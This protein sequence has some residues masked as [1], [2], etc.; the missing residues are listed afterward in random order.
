M[1]FF[2]RDILQYLAA[3]LLFFPFLLAPGYVAAYWSG[4]FHFRSLGLFMRLLVAVCLSFAL[5]PIPVYLLWRFPGIVSVWV[6]YAAVWTALV[7]I[8]LRHRPRRYR[9]PKVAVA[10][11]VAVTAI[12]IAELVDLPSGGHL[13]LSTA[14]YD[15]GFRAGVVDGL[16]RTAHLPPA[17]PFYYPGHPAP[18]RYHYFWFMICSLVEQLGRSFLDGRAALV[19]S[20]VWAA[21]G[22]LATIAV[23]VRFFEG[24]SGE[25]GRKRALLVMAATAISGLDILPFVHA[26]I[27]QWYQGK[28]E[29][30]RWA[31]IDWW[32]AGG[33]ITSWPSSVIWVPNHTAS[34][35]ACLVSGLLLWEAKQSRSSG[36]RVLLSALGGVGLAT[37]TGLSVLVAFAFVVFLLLMLAASAIGMDK[38]ATIVLVV[39]LGMSAVMLAPYLLELRSAHSAGN[40]VLVAGIRPFSW[41]ETV[42][43]ATQTTSAMGKFTI[44]ALL[45]PLNYFMELGALSLVAVWKL[46]SL[47]T[48]REGVAARE[49]ILASMFMVS[50]LVGSFLRLPNADDLGWRAWLIGQFVLLFW[51]ADFIEAKLLSP[52]PHPRLFRSWATGIFAVTAA[53]GVLTNVAELTLLRTYMIGIDQGWAAPDRL[54]IPGHASERAFDLRAAL[55]WLDGHEPRSVVIQE[56]PQLTDATYQG[57]WSHRQTATRGLKYGPGDGGDQKEFEQLVDLLTPLFYQQTTAEQADNIC[58]AAGVNILVLQDYDPAWPA[59]AVLW[60]GRLLFSTRHVR[61]YSCGT[62]AA[63]V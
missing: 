47:V 19:G 24:K 61:L 27:T 10:I 12:V 43:S 46:R 50:F 8:A 49:W 13:Y 55:R 7:F 1:T 41:A 18:F 9:I 3:I 20:V 26:A 11:G 52:T 4:A 58:R 29:L 62:N 56:D 28:H 60:R 39:A 14:V 34:L 54:W 31:T 51:T 21:F 38:Q 36:R 30:V 16:A 35:V 5:T 2:W 45:L 53:I 33:Q 6:C 22:I 25:A 37:G 15:H 59:A 44:A 17:N 32:N 42:T 57:Y 63:G 48:A 23:T 40:A